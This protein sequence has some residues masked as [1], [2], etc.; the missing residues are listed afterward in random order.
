MKKTISTV[1]AAMAVVGGTGAFGTMVLTF[2]P[3]DAQAQGRAAGARS[4]SAGVRGPSPGVRTH[5]AGVRGPAFHSGA[6]VGVTIGAPF[7]ASPWWW[8]SPYPYY[9]YGYGYGYPPYYYPPAVYVQEQPSVYV[10]R[11]APVPP[12][13]SA[14]Q[15]Q[16]EPYWYYCQDSKTYYPYVQKCA[17]PW[18]RVIPYATQ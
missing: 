3:M 9:G 5:V 2:A 7:I 15:A 14:P 18:Q 13:S 10:E 17:T 1:L 12:A 16:P 8:Y 4:S 6:R 11:Q